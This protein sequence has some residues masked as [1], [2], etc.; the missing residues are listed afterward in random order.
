LAWSG[1]QLE[2]WYAIRAPALDDEQRTIAAGVLWSLEG[3]AGQRA[4][5][6]WSMG[7]DAARKI[8]GTDWMTPFLTVMVQDP[9]RAVRYIAHRSLT[10]QPEANGLCNWDPLAPPAEQFQHTTPILQAWGARKRLA[11]AALLITEKGE[12]DLAGI[13]RLL[14]KRNER[15]VVLNE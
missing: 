13:Q 7:W 1:E 4:L 14:S 12:V 10:R 3:D 6:A 5:M 15:T 11:K 2:R 8:S 9:Y